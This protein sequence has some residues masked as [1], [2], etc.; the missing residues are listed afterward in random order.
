MGLRCPD[1]RMNSEKPSLPFHD[2]A[3]LPGHEDGLREAQLTVSWWGCAARTWGWTQRSPAY[4]FMM[5]LRCPDM[6]MD[7]GKPSLPFHDGAALPGHED[8]LREAQLTVSWWGCAARTWGWTQRSPAYR[9]MMGLR[10]PDM[11]MDSGKPI[12]CCWSLP[13]TEMTHVP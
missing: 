1:I 5:G 13:S 11:R 9:F 10:C 4:R 3:A 12:F 7:S 8:G 2:G 6:R